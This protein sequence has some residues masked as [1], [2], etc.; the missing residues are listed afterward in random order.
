[1]LEQ[2]KN[3]QVICKKIGDFYEFF[4]ENAEI[5]HKELQ[6]TLTKTKYGRK[7]CGIPYHAI[8]NDTETLKNKGITL[9][10]ED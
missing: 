6:Y 5:I 9:I 3:K 10:I 8:T 2:L 1:L 7:I 4:D